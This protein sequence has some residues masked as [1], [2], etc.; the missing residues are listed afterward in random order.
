MRMSNYVR[1]GVVTA[2]A[3]AAVGA[4]IAQAATSNLTINI[5]N[6]AGPHGRIDGKLTSTDSSCVKGTF[7]KLH[8][9]V[10]RG[11]RHFIADGGDKADQH[12]KWVV[13]FENAI[14]PGKYYASVS[15]SGACPAVKTTIVKVTPP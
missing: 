7:V 1:T 5:H 14:P 4:A 3:L 10:P 12:G 11:G 13:N 15:K 9:D 8:Y 2:L 6:S